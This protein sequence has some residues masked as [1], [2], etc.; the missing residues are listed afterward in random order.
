MACDHK[1]LES[2]LN[3]LGKYQGSGQ[4]HV[5]SGC[6]YRLGEQHKAKGTPFNPGAVDDLPISQGG[7]QRHKNAYEAYKLAYEA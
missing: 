7:A 5:C 2:V 6:A 1:E 4:R 3:S